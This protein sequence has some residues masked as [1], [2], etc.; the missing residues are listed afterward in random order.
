MLYYPTIRALARSIPRGPNSPHAD[1]PEV[2]IEYLINTNNNYDIVKSSVYQLPPRSNREK[3]L[4]RYSPQLETKMKY[5]IVHYMSTHRLSE[6][7]QAFVNQMSMVAIPSKVQDALTNSK[8]ASD[9]TEEM[10][11][12]E[13]NQT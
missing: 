13:N 3:P 12:L 8:W 5:P 10:Q 9:M 11:A 4:G 6:A 7:C 1:I 2:S